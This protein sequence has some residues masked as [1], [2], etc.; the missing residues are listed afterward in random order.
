MEEGAVASFFYG[1]GLSLGAKLVSTDGSLSHIFFNN[2]QAFPS[3]GEK[4]KNAPHVART[5]W[6]YDIYIYEFRQNIRSHS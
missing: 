1:L 3:G 6:R 4:K 5:D 2:I